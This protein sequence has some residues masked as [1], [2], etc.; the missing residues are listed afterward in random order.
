MNSDLYLS[1]FDFK[2]YDSIFFVTLCELAKIAESTEILIL[3]IE[4]NLDF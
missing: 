1:Y 4:V 3:F 2:V